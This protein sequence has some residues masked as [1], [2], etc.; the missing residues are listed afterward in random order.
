MIE[1]HASFEIA[2][3]AC[4]RVILLSLPGFYCVNLAS[5]DSIYS[6]TRIAIIL[7]ISDIEA[8]NIITFLATIKISL[9]AKGYSYT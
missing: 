8:T 9:I 6:T 3:S 5:L 1:Q 7:F 4:A 2:H